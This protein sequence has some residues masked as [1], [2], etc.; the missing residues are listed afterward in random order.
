MPF[1]RSAGV[2]LHPTSLPGGEGIGDLGKQAFA[3]ADL[4]ESMGIGLWQ[5]LPVGPTGA[6]NSPYQSLSSAAGNPLLISLQTLVDLGLLNASDLAKHPPNTTAVEFDTV[7]TFKEAALRKAFAAFDAGKGTAAFRAGLDAFAEEEAG[8]LDGFSLFVAGKRHFKG[9]AWFQ[10]SDTDLITRTETALAAMRKEL[11]PEIAF[12]TWC[13]YVF[14]T[15]WRELKAYCNERRI[16]LMG[17]VPI[18]VAHDSA[19]VWAAPQ[20]FK[21]DKKGRALSVAG[22][23]PDYFSETGQ[24]WGNPIFRWDA[25]KADGY[26]WWLDRIER[27]LALV[28]LLRIDHF[29]GFAAYWEVPAGEKTA[30][31]GT[32]IDGPRDDFFQAI[33]NKLGDLPIIA[34]DLGVITEDVDALRLGRG[35]PG[36]K[37]LQFAFCDGAENY[38][39]HNYETNC[40]VYTG[41]HDNDTTRGWYE[42]S[43]PDYAHY[44]S[45]AL[46]REH[47][48]ARRYLGVDGGNIAHDLMRLALR[49]VADTAIVPLQDILNLDNE[50]R[51]NRPGAADGQW[52]WRVTDRQLADTPVGFVRDMV[53]LYGREPQ[54]VC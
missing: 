8:W 28:D 4:L 23:P 45:E 42:G 6:A 20:Y 5:V 17:D 12:Q 41:T 38:L 39:P 35:I 40:V 11:A 3:F 33:Q 48:K 16:R 9:K 43:G 10:W 47:D 19:D 36:M 53:Y 50:A 2:L 18:Y 44:D 49:S 54:P 51:M 31:N 22:V 14:F 37:V 29:R 52:R 25:I 26:R 30:I 24:L 46:G 34:E 13:Q 1:P 7:R 32:W 15:Q 21:L 27:T